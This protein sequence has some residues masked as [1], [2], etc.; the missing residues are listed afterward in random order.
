MAMTEH[1]GG[2]D[3]PT[4]LEV[5]VV[6]M[7]GRFPGA[8]DIHAFWRNLRDGVESITVFTREEL[9]A[10]GTRAA[11][12]D[13]PGFVPAGALVP[14]ADELD[15]G[16]F[17]MNPR[18][19][20]ILNPQHRLFLECAWSA[21]EHA[22]YDPGRVERPVGVFAGSGLNAYL[23]RVAGRDDLV[24]A[25]G[26]M[27][28]VL[29]NDKDHLASG[30]A[31]RLNL[32]GPAVA[33]QTACSTSLVAV[34]VA[35]QSLING[36][37]D[38]ALAGGS[39]V[40]VPLRMGYLYSPEGIASPDGHCRAFDAGARGTVRGN[41]A[42]VVALRRLEDA[43]ADGDTIH[44]VIR[45]SAVNNDGAQKVGYTAPSVTG[46]ARVIREAL[47][48]A[49]VDAA[50]VQYVETH[51]SGTPLGDAIE[52]KA[53]AEVLSRAGSGPPWAIGS[54]KTNVGH[55]DA[56]AGVAGLIKTV[57]ALGRRQ[58]PPSL[59]CADPHPEIRALGGR[60]FVN[61]ELRPWARNGT[62]RRAG[63]SS[64]GIG[65]TN[66]HVVLEE[67]PAPEPPAP[68]R[69][70][71]LLV[72]SARTPTAL[73]AA[74]GKLAA[75]L[76]AESPPLADA[77][78]TLRAGRA[79]ME[80]RLAVVCRDAE[81][82]A[83]ALRKAA[84]RGSRAVPRNGRPLAFLFP[85]V[86]MQ[87][88]D[89]GRGLYHAEP[90]F[91]DAVDECCAILRPVLGSD[92]RDLLF[93]PAGSASPQPNDDHPSAKK[94][95]GG[96]DLRRLLGGDT[97]A[98]ED[99]PLDDT[100]IAQP[101]VFVVEYAL[102]RL[103]M[104]WGVRPSAMAGHSLGEYVAACVAG[105]LRLEDALRLVALRA[106]L[107][108]ALPA[109][110]MLAVPLGEAALR[111]ILPA[112]L[113]VAAV[114]TPES[115]VAAGPVEEIEAFR[116]ALAERGT[117]S[118][119][120]P[121]RHAFHSRAMA[122]A[123]GEVERLVAGFEL[124][125]PEIPFVSGVTGTW[126]TDDEA[127]S[128]AYWSRHLCRTVRFADCV[129]ALRGEPG[130]ALLEVGPGQTLGAWA[131]Q[132]PAG[133]EP[134]DPVVLGSLRHRHNHVSDQ[135][136]LLEALAGLWTAGVAVDWAAFGAG[137]RRR[138][139]PL[140]GY[141]FERQRY[142]V[143]PHPA[144]AAEAG[145][146]GT[147]A[148]DARPADGAAGSPDL[149]GPD[150]MDDQSPAVQPVE[151]APSP[152]ERTLLE[153][154]KEIVAELTGRS[155]G[156]VETDADLFRIGFDSLLL[157]QAIQAIEKRVGVRVSL[158]ELLEE[159]STLGALAGHL[160]R[161]L[162]PGAAIHAGR[163]GKLEQ[164]PEMESAR[165][166][167]PSVDGSASPASEPVSATPGGEP[168]R[169]IAVP[170]HVYPPPA[171]PP[172]AGAGDGTLERLFAQQLQAMGQLMAQQIAAA[173]GAAGHPA[174]SASAHPAAS[175]ATS[176]AA[177]TLA[178]APAGEAGA[179][180]GD[181][182]GAAGRVKVQAVEPAP[183]ARIQPETFVPF[184]AVNPEGR[185]AMT[186]R[187]REYLEGFIARYVERT[188]GSKAHQVR[189]HAPLADTRVTARFRR[190]WKEILYPIVSTRALGSRVW[191]VDGNEYVDTGM[192]F[193]C[194]LFGHAPEFVSR[195]MRDQIERGYGVGPQ[196]PHAGRAAELVCE[197]GGVD[198][199][200]FCNSGTEAVMGAIRAA[201]TYSGRDR[202]AVFSGAYHGWADVVL[203]RLTTG[204]QREIRPTSPG[205]S[206]APLQDVLMLEWDDPASLET[207]ARHLDELA[208]VMV[209]PVQSRRLDIHPRAFLHEL[210]R[211][212]REAG[213]LLLFD[214]LITGFRVHPGGAQAHF[215]VKA[216]LVTYGK[217]VAGGLPMGVVAGRREVMDVFDGGVFSYGDDSY[218][219]AQRTVFAGAFFKHP[220]S[221]AVACAVL[222]EIR[223][224]GV[225]M[226]DALNERT[227]RL[228]ARLNAFFEAGRYPVTAVQF[229]SSFRFFFG[230]AF[231][232]PDLFN[233]HL[234][235]NGI[236]MIPETGTHF[237]STAHT[238]D[239]LE[240]FFQ[241]VRASVE[242]MRDGGFLPPG[243][244]GGAGGGA[245]GDGTATASAPAV[246]SAAPSANGA[247]GA[248]EIRRVRLTDGQRQ[249]WI[250]SQMGE[251]A[252][253]AYIESAA[254]RLHGALDADALHRALQSLVDRHDALRITL[255]PD[256][257]AQLVH[258]AWAVE[259]PREDFRGVPAESR[260]AAVEAWVRRM[261][262]RPF[263]LEHGPVARFALGRVAEDEHV[264][265]FS[266]HHVA[267]DG[268]SFGVLW[269]E[270][271]A[272]YAAAR[273]GRPAALPPAP[274]YAAAVGAQG[275]A[276]D[277]DAPAQAYWRSQFA[278]GVPVLELPTDRPRPPVRAYRGERM[279]RAL[280]P[281]LAGRLAAAVRPHGLTPFHALL[282]A[283]ALW[284]SRLAG[285]DDVVVGTPAAGQA[286]GG[287]A[288]GLVGYAVNVL[289]IRVR[290]DEAETFLELAR[291][292]RSSTLRGVQHQAF[293]FPR[294]VEAVLRT[295][296]SGRAPL[297][298]VL[299]NLDRA[300]PPGAM[301]LGGLR[302]EAAQN[303]GGG[304]KVDLD[305]NF[306]ETGDDLSLACEYRADLF[307]GAT[308]ERWIAGLE[309][310]LERVAG[311]P[312]VR[313][314]DV[315]TLGE[316]ERRLLEE[317]NRTEV[318][319]PRDRCLHHLFAA[320]AERTPG[321][322]AVVHPGGAVSYRELDERANR[323][324]HHLRR[325]GVGPEVRVAI[326]L[327]R[328]PEMPEAILGVLKAGGAYVPIDPQYPAARQAYMLEDSGAR[329]L[330]T[331]DALAERPAGG[332]RVVRLDGGRAEIDRESGEA[333]ES[334]AV[335]ENLAYVIYTSGSTGRPK[336][337]AVAHRAVVN[338]ATD[339]AERM[340]LRGT[341]RVLQFASPAFDVVVEELYPT[342][343]A[344]AAVAVAGADLFTP[345]ELVR[346]IRELGVTSFELPTAYWHQWAHELARSGARVPE[347]V[348]FVIVGGERVSPERL[349]EWAGAGAPLV[350]AFGLTETACTSTT[351]WLEAGRDHSLRW[352]NLP[353]GAPLGNVRLHVLD[354]GLR[355][356]PVG[357]PGELY[358]AGE[359]VARGYLGRPGLTAGRF[360]P[361]PFSSGP[362]A[363]A[364]RTGDRVRWLADGNLEFLGRIDHQ[365]KI[366]GFRIETGEVE[367]ALTE[368]PGVREAFVMARED[369]AG[370]RRLAAY[371]V[372]SA[373]AVDSTEDE[374][375]PLD[376]DALRAHLRARLPEHMVPAAFV[377]LD[378]LPLSPNGKVDRGRLPAPEYA[379]RE[380]Y[381]APETEVEARLAE[382]WA[383][384][385]G[386]E[387]V[388]RHDGFFEL[389]G[390]SLLAMRLVSRVREALEVEL[391]L[392]AVFE[393]PTVA[394]VAERVEALRCAALPAAPAVLPVARGGPLP[395]SFAQ[396]R[397][398]FLDRLQPGG[399]F[400]N[401]PVFLRLRGE[402]DTPALERAL[403]ETVRR[404][405]ALRTTLPE[406][407]GA[408]VQVIAPFAGF[409][410]PVD[411]LS[412]LPEAERE[413]E[414]RRR[415]ADEAGRPFDLQAGPLFRARL[416]RL[417]GEDHA[418]LVSMHHAV[419][420]EWSLEVWFRELA[421]LYGAFRRGEP[422]PLPGL[423]VHYA[424]F[425]AWQRARL[426]GEALDSLLAWWKERLSGAP[427]LIS[428]PTDRPRPAMM[429]FR[430][431][432]VPLHL[433]PALVERLEGVAR[434][435]G[436][437][438]YMVL[439]TAFRAL[440]A[441]YAGTGDIVVGTT[442]AGR[443][444][445]ETEGLVGLFMNTLA[446]RTD[447]SG[448]PQFAG[449]VRRV[450]ETV[451]GAFEHQEVPFE[452][453]VDALRLERSLAH[454]PL[455]QVLFEL[456]EGGGGA[457][458]LAG[459]EVGA[460]E[461]EGGPART[462]LSV[463]LWIT[464]RGVEGALAY[465][466]DL[467]EPATARRMAAQLRRVL[468]QAAA[469]PELRLSRLNPVD[470]AER[471][472]LL[473]WS[474]TTAPFPADACVHQL[475][476][477]QARRTP[478][479]AAVT[480]GAETLTYRQLDERANRL[481]NHLRGLGV[482][483]ET[484][485]GIC[486]ERGLDL[487]PCILGVM[488]AGGAYVP[489]DPAHPAERT[490]Y[491][492]GDAGVRVVLTQE[493]LRGAVP[494]PAG[495][496]LV[497]VDGAARE[498]IATE[499][500]GAPVTG[501]TPENLAY[502]IY[503]SGSTGRPKGVAMHHRGVANYIHWGVEA[504]GAGRGNGSPVFSSM[505]VDLT[506]TN[507]LALFAG[508]PVRLLPEENAV[509]ALAEALR[510]GAGFGPVKITPVHLS[511]LTPLLSAGDARGA[512]H[513]LVIGADFLSAEPTLFWQDQAPGV[514][515]MNE[516]GP[517]ETVVGCSAY[518]LPPGAHRAGPVPVG[519][520]IPN[521]AFHVLDAHGAPVPVGVPGELYIGGV[522]VAR[523]YLGRPGLS[524]EKFVPDPFAGDGRRMY[525]TGDRARWLEGGDLMILGRTDSQVKIRGYRVELGEIEAVLRRHPGVRGAVVVVRED[526]PGDRRL[527]AYVAGDADAP[528][529]RGYLGR[530]V[531]PYMVPDAFVP[532][533][534]LPA[535]ATGKLDPRTL[536]APRYEGAGGEPDGPRNYVEAQLIPLW[537]ALLGVEGI[538]ATQSFFD[539]G[540]NSFLALRLF[541]QVNRRLE[542]DLPVATLFAGAT[543]RHMADA[544]LEQRREGARPP[545]SVVPLQP[546]G[547]LPALFL[548]HAADRNV[549]G[550]VNLVRHLGADQP[551][552]GVRDVG[553]DLGRPIEQIAAEHVAAIREAQPEGPYSL[554]GWSFGGIVAFEM[555]LQ[556]ERAGREVAF[557]GM[558]DTISP[559]LMRDWA[560]R[561][562]DTDVL[563]DLAQDAA[564]LRGRTLHLQPRD[565]E[566]MELDEAVRHAAR[567]L[568]EQGAMPPDAAPAATAERLMAACREVFDRTRSF[569][570]YHPGRL[571][572]PLALFRATEVQ[573]AREAFLAT[574]TDD[575]RR[576][577]GW[578]AHVDGPLRVYDV[579]AAHAAL[580]SEP[581][582]RVLARHL[583]DA[584]ESA[585][586]DR[587]AAREAPDPSLAENPAVA[588]L[589]EV[590]GSGDS[591][592]DG[593]AARPSAPVAA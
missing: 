109:G 255:T 116:A 584:L 184:Q 313:V 433:P 191:D 282:A 240:T 317:W 377:V 12:L 202:I 359:G 470:P 55:M 247:A 10:A 222:E 71:Q 204:D 360:V 61:T 238:D 39:A 256:G 339:F 138:R 333:P 457:P 275:A 543:V 413:A 205:V 574:R 414:V 443:T 246:V 531:P 295:R 272:L 539:L 375:A 63:V 249:L 90:V 557:V 529:L 62:P 440:L 291:R 491:V 33:V 482:G 35:C 283:Q 170:P 214:E 148:I 390:H 386:V 274:D 581:H 404:H 502:V 398:W 211:I 67:A 391:P 181:S 227:T 201:R 92:L 563:V 273:G 53:L 519:R 309:R 186:P 464:P 505:A 477:A 358:V 1:G 378:S 352:P 60:V 25:V 264:L 500:A 287:E 406:V 388:G 553:E 104:G 527:V 73:A 541:T 130:L 545:G 236:Y 306:V 213:T 356:A 314:R 70:L 270:L 262:R 78:F 208:L 277:D 284:L 101:A 235:L 511:L 554:V 452:R 552:F 419:T 72:L 528:A 226:Y 199:A 285:Q 41:G 243:P 587:A 347:C 254:I 559:A 251:E 143:D 350:H 261:V 137:E 303:F 586:G 269:R 133:G 411:D 278:D 320:Q 442:V 573:P 129:G 100:R 140:P 424:D 228:M 139:I 436:A 334:G 489:V 453:L 219:T 80:H 475:F 160:D 110:A 220:L 118:R 480:F 410:L 332:A 434:R 472:R 381:A 89:M 325:L 207:L 415:A 514:R 299:M 250:E 3:E 203:G 4:G 478:D 85:G 96:W 331:L 590:A 526:R 408:P 267:V 216:D 194:N 36:E 518:T 588:G 362:G 30:A 27:R 490:G 9:L 474:G 154:L 520:A 523:G 125:A 318:P 215:G 582:V 221:M 507:L 176:P 50:T 197:L 319:F 113:D 441:R 149:K 252:S 430:G 376:A 224:R 87:Y 108:G 487:V 42:G 64:F 196:S 451:L 328:G 153:V 431:A 126:I 308:I 106:E 494:T 437:T 296:E 44:A 585:R 566:G 112:E 94:E 412:G 403:G 231:Q 385:L 21:L 428:L 486:L 532:L 508:T 276:L 32:R 161:V 237:L 418:L 43:L 395:L 123:A 14:G 223:R 517:T 394:Q 326:L 506:L 389:G 22:G 537:E 555:A 107:I 567:A 188:K 193:G 315:E 263:D 540:G 132:H 338:F 225:P 298:S 259:L 173:T 209:E 522:G 248:G 56:A 13:D 234:V 156:Q 77:A 171:P 266:A 190:A 134:E 311:D 368:H 178:A 31:Y 38:L 29:A 449:A 122:A 425:A 479:A 570:A 11:V 580:G 124:R 59:N 423:P 297:F 81:E 103:W 74:A 407:E 420:D 40:V 69:D 393:G 460:V 516:Y 342:W 46:Q 158:I 120:L 48:V 571:A 337:V 589:L 54:V 37:C 172:A 562:R 265:L 230:A 380:R 568:H 455:F 162:P 167:V 501:V 445:G 312:G 185:G 534:S 369:A 147:A 524:A 212:T 164:V 591:D 493:R 354:A 241:A 578:A 351:L 466:T 279:G 57:L 363:R 324:A 98:E 75:H 51:G 345:P 281:A 163:N 335:P 366:R 397:L 268:W 417:A 119:R 365:V 257:E 476:E 551:A 19:A 316:G 399:S 429:S 538:G 65:G 361:D 344:G 195:A 34:H 58:I 579:P 374:E 357:V 114:N 322:P 383:A 280:G 447:L 289:P 168:R 179:R 379:S 536:P 550:Y 20:E 23:E 330:L 16:V 144:R 121:A 387:R 175:A 293:S 392:R 497:C 459:V 572:A 18:D 244:D 93:S 88:V 340:G 304:V 200:V 150:P 515:L 141:P 28:I 117:V 583:R 321:A 6:G 463:A 382:L 454:S 192:S 329:V 484:R 461:M 217:I 187:Q 180:E 373:G 492:L 128:P 343:F 481:A 146:A 521:L 450:R 17:G 467:F 49:G 76:E 560:S 253:L 370:D 465:A 189:Y 142:W 533:E 177:P 47:S 218:P 422:S 504:Y 68:S 405:E 105:V 488:K 544:I 421:A 565:L 271:D 575:E 435:E 86:G 152:R 364:Y 111:E 499:P 206:P 166:V 91:R 310:L 569:S 426:Q 348:R 8:D 593:G 182:A 401:V 458:G 232:H 229:S 300:G 165:A 136:F 95:K 456:R 495:A 24:R 292:V 512:A 286:A 503:T 558:L 307:D 52:L 131:M 260:E 371:V 416:L 145:A 346:A 427:E 245:G 439:Q 513:T 183:R 7:A 446:L 82:G 288:A 561:E 97:D 198:R 294:L 471:A 535:T 547:S 336:G 115:C 509:E 448:D 409:T 483:P 102:A 469:S 498:R 242:A 157:L 485:V 402:L 174:A 5:A 159:I 127:R 155:P 15:A 233:H 462:D 151:T 396:E 290:V 353:V 302:A 496:A 66:A 239:D 384:L 26:G 367:A 99:S 468:E 564:A 169:T 546:G 576:A 83:R 438:L 473:A 556:L 327:G 548:V 432:H 372:P 577:L 301:S 79:Q 258:P 341:D 305:V 2:A 530:S 444:R 549:M 525:R 592:G 84:A 135:R 323:L 542:C 45:G 510:G 210:R 349:A 355:P 400:F